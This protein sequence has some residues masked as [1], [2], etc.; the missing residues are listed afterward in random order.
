MPS[1][2]RWIQNVPSIEID[3]RSRDAR[4]RFERIDQLFELS[5]TATH[6]RLRRLL[7]LF[8][9]GKFG[10]L[11]QPKTAESARRTRRVLVP[12]R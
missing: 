4:L 5:S 3:Q 1:T 12:A 11:P 7:Y 9:V 6:S 8:T 10:G 2:N